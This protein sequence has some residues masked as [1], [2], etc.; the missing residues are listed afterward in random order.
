[1]VLEV[2]QFQITPG[3]EDAF[4]QAYATAVE[5]VAATPGF[6]SARLVRGV[7][8][9]SQFVLLVEWESVEA[10]EVFRGGDGF[11]AWRAAI[12]PHFAAPPHVEHY[13]DV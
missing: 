8:S 6:R 1:M 10:H 11:G 4:A 3:S 13:R 9:P 7:E 12:G 5:H 2:A